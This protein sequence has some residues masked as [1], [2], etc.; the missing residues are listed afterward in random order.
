MVGGT[1]EG[2]GVRVD[3]RDIYLRPLYNL[4]NKTHDIQVIQLTEAVPEGSRF[5]S[6]NSEPSI[7]DDYA[8]LRTAGYGDVAFT[9]E[10]ESGQL[11]QVDV[12][13]QPIEVCKAVYPEILQDMHICAGY[14]AGGC[15]SC[16]GDAGGPLYLFE[17]QGEI[18]QVGIVS[19]G[20]SCVQPKKPWCLYAAFKSHK[21]DEG[22]W[23]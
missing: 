18:V 9:P 17:S 3:I 21:L 4:E 15:D 10:A 19:F 23:C 5:V 6:V 1:A 7:P 20:I 13:V 16:K 2:Q 12:P 22:Y 8:F 14:D 11:L